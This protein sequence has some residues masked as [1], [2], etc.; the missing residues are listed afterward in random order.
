MASIADAPEK[1]RLAGAPS[2]RGPRLDTGE[3]EPYHPNRG[4]NPH[5]AC[6]RTVAS[7]RPGGNGGGSQERARSPFQQSAGSR[8][9]RGRSR[10]ARGDREPARSAGADLLRVSR[11][12]GVRRRGLRRHGNDVS[13]REVR[14]AAAGRDRRGVRQR[15]RLPAAPSRAI[16]PG[17]SA[18]SPGRVEVALAVA[19]AAACRRGRRPHRVRFLRH[20]RAGAALAS[21]GA[22]A[23]DR[24]R[25]IRAGPRMGGAAAPR[26]AGRRGRRGGRIPR[27][28]CRPRSVLQRLGQLGAD[29]VVFTPGYYPGRRRPDVQSA[30]FRQR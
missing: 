27:R 9:Y 8:Q 13:A 12:A 15:A 3:R 23:R 11:P 30:R 26:S 7:A 28:R 21:G 6:R 17:R 24:D 5:P 10:P 2:R 14:R 4:F 29:A 20:D 22:A 25:R 1:S 18:G 19:S 16:V